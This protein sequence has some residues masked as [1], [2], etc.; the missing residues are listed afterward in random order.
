MTIAAPDRT[1]VGVHDPLFV[2]ALVLDDGRGESAQGNGVVAIVCCDLIGCGFE[3]TEQVRQTIEA[4]TG[5]R[6]LLLNF[7][8]Q[9]SSRFLAKRGE[10]GERGTVAGA[11]EIEWNTGVHEAIVACVVEANGAAAPATLRAGRAA[12]QVGFNRRIVLDGGQIHMGDNKDGAVVPW[13][14]VLVAEPFEETQGKAADGGE[15]LDGA[16]GKPIA[17][18]LEHAAH[19]V[20]VPDT[21]NLISADFPGSAVA[22]MRAELGDEC[23]VMFGQG[24]GANVNA[25]PLRTTHENADAAGAKLGEAALEA[26]RSAEPIVADTLA[27]G[28]KRVDLPCQRLPSMAVWQET[29]DHLELDWKRGTESGRPVDWI[30]EEVH[31]LMLAR[32]DEIKGQIERDEQPADR[33]LDVAAVMLGREWALV[34]FGG[35]IFCEYELWADEAAPFDRVMTFGYTNG[36]DGYVASDEALAM[37]AKG[38]YEAGTFPCW[39][40][41]NLGAA[42][43]IGTEA[44]IQQA[45]ASLWPQ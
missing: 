29:L 22:R 28:Q 40:A 27:F 20:I 2:R 39:W 10:G 9:H 26:M 25:Y 34:S 19:P 23:V 6:N 33:R 41:G 38:G 32:L 5:I 4:A 43:A 30:T 8:H 37:G 3:V 15:P 17:V 13:V 14:N 35:E 7:G 21:S 42:L 16:R 18:L 31:E 11:D 1:S 36:I 24:C 12:A 44:R 45:M